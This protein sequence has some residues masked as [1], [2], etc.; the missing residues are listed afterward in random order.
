MGHGVRSALVTSMIRA[1]VEEH[2]EITADP[3]ELLTRVNHALAEILTQ[4]R[5]T[6]F[7]TCFLPRR[8]RE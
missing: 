6:I 3:G 4:A 1:L 8:R 7:A 2:A 5:T